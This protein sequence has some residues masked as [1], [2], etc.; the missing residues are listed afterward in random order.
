MSSPTLRVTVRTFA[1]L[2]EHRSADSEE[3][4]VPSQTSVAQVFQTLFG[5]GPLADLPVAYALNHALVP[6]HTLV[7]DGDTLAFLP[8]V[9]GG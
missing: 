8:P 2:R 1:Q 3:L 4:D 6:P 9:G 7:Q 5:A